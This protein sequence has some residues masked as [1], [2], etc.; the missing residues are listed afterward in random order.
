MSVLKHL[1]KR[2]KVSVGVLAVSSTLVSSA[3]AK[4]DIN[5]D[6]EKFT[7]DNGLT[8]IAVSYTHLTLP[9]SDLV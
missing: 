3:F 2:L 1:T 8:V 7:T 9:T 5:I 6:Y 4:N